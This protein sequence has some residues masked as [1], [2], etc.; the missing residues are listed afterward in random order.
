M[1]KKRVQTEDSE[2]NIFSK[3]WGWI[4]GKVYDFRVFL[5]QKF[6]KKSSPSKANNKKSQRNSLIFYIGFFALPLLQLL[7]FYFV[8][9][10]NSF[11]LAFQR[12]DLKTFQ[13]EWAGL[14]NFRQIFYNL[15]LPGDILLVS[16]LNSL[17][18]YAANLL[19]GTSLALLFSYY[20]YKKYKGSEFFRVVLFL[21][22]IIS[23]VVMV[24][25]FRFFTDR[26]I[27]DMSKLCFGIKIEGFLTNVNTR[28]GT[29]LFYNIWVGFGTSIL[30]YVSAMTRIPPE[31]TESANLDGASDIREF[32]SIT[33]P[34]IY[35]TITAFL[36]IGVS[37]IFTSQGAIY[38]FYGRYLSDTSL[39]TLGYYLF[40]YV[41]NS[42][43]FNNYASASAAGLLG[44]FISAPI[45]LFFRWLLDKFDPMAEV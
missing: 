24:T 12:Y 28:F 41:Q 25:M 15:S 10:I 14:E 1:K 37:G 16:L 45:V 17:K 32:F 40:Q 30:M 34:S 11:L 19:V 5:N 43:G 8:V 33:L 26:G 4:T 18:L 20:I 6:S 7:I 31:I 22:S 21:P 23:S 36:I 27:P 13:F 42:D 29:I 3:I 38:E 44:T 2:M 9:N 35:S 39:S